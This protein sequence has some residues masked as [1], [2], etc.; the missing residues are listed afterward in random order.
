MTTKVVESDVIINQLRFGQDT[1]SSTSP[2]CG[3]GP[4]G[5]VM[6]TIVDEISTR[7][8]DCLMAIQGVKRGISRTQVSRI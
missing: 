2:P 4:L 3:S 1:F 5:R 8:V 7:K 6:E